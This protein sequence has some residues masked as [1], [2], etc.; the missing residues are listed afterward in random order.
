MPLIVSEENAMCNFE[1]ARLLYLSLHTADPSTTGASECTDS[2]YARQPLVWA[3]AANGA[4]AA[5]Q[6]SFS[7]NPNTFTSFGFWDSAT[8]GNYLGGN[9]LN[10]P[11]SPTVASI[12][13]VTPSLTVS[14]S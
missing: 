8:G 5:T 6:V 9:P 13:K 7:V 11:Q 10:S 4:T 12:V 3:A 1:S 14:V 2:T